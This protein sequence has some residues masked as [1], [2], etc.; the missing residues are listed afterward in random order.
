MICDN[1]VFAGAKQPSVHKCQTTERAYLQNRLQIY[2]F[3]LNVANIFPFFAQK[4]RYDLFQHPQNYCL[5][6]S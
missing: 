3:F 6:L 2:C 1:S 5:H 4:Y